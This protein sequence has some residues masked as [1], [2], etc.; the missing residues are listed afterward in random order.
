MESPF[1]IVTKKFDV[2]ILI[3]NYGVDYRLVLAIANECETVF[4]GAKYAIFQQKHRFN[5]R[6][7]RVRCE[8]AKG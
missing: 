8:K 4:C 7:V 5:G 3:N 1:S 2:N 6:L